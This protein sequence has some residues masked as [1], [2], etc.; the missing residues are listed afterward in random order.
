MCVPCE[1][2]NRRQFRVLTCAIEASGD[3]VQKGVLGGKEAS[4]G[5]HLGEK[6]PGPSVDAKRTPHHGLP[7]PFPA[8]PNAHGRRG[9]VEDGVL[10]LGVREWA[11][12]SLISPNGNFFSIFLV[13]FFRSSSDQ[14][15]PFTC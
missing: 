5:G 1:E 11:F 10:P 9:G 6:M 4:A 2:E 15:S 12:G 8:G 13:L 3:G 7:R 14:K